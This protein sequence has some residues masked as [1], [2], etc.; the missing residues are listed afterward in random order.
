MDLVFPFCATW[1]MTFGF[2]PQ[3]ACVTLWLSQQHLKPLLISQTHSEVHKY[4]LFCTLYHV[5]K[6]HGFLTL[7]G[8]FFWNSVTSKSSV[9]WISKSRLSDSQARCPAHYL[10]YT[11]PPANQDGGRYREHGR[12]VG[13][14]VMCLSQTPTHKECGVHQSQHLADVPQ[15][16]DAGSHLYSHQLETFENDMLSWWF[17]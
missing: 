14:Y 12:V 9:C 2:F 16:L 6:Q 4:S 1:W 3:K 5:T 13:L 10:C 8:F 15:L 11:W 7:M 17:M